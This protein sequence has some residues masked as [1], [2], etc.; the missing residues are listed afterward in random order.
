MMS[1]GAAH[2]GIV[3]PASDAPGADAREHLSLASDAGG[4]QVAGAHVAAVAAVAEAAD[5]AGAGYD[6]VRA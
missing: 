1:A 4:A 5:V 2:R 3:S 6:E